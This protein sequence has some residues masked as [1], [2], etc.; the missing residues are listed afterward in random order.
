MYIQIQKINEEFEQKCRYLKT[1]SLMQSNVPPGSVNRL[2]P[3]PHST[4]PVQPNNLPSAPH[5]APPSLNHQGPHNLPP[6]L[7]L[8]PAQQQPQPQPQPPHAEA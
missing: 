5:R 6:T 8:Q 4:L 2:I 7:P 3:G 1:A